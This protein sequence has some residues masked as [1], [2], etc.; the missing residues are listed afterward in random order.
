MVPKFQLYWHFVSQIGS[1]LII[2]FLILPIRLCCQA[3]IN[4]SYV[5]EHEDD[6]LLTLA[7]YFTLLTFQLSLRF[8]E[9]GC[10]QRDLR[11][12]AAN[13]GGNPA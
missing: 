4:W 2:W 12:D 9:A 5:M 10:R 11:D 6:T 8:G 1:C 3:S 13:V 7:Y